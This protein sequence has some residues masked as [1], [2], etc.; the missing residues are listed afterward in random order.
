MH[1]SC[2]YEYGFTDIEILLKI[3]I[4]DLFMVQALEHFWWNLKLSTIS[5]QVLNGIMLW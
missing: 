5:P 1:D 3:L 2:F 4:I